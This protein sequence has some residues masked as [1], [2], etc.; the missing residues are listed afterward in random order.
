MRKQ[1][2]VLVAGSSLRLRPLTDATPKCLL[3]VGG[4]TILDRLLER[5]ADAG[6]T[7]GVLVTGYLAHR[8][9]QHLDRSPPPLELTLAPNPDYATTNNAVSLLAARAHLGPGSLI[10]CD[11]DVVLHG[12]A[13]H[14][15]LSEPAPCALLVD[16]QTALGGEEM[17]VLLDEQGR[18]TRLSKALDPAASAGESI[19]IQKVD[20]AALDLL[21]PT[22]GDLVKS[23]KTQVFYE[24]AFQ[25]M[26]DAGTLFRAVPITSDEWTEID[27]LADL[28]DARARFVSR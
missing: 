2:V 20:G 27:S 24:A 22:L 1:A 11:G 12:D 15:L 7:R 8:I 5:L 23:G 17:K 13:L 3:E 28:E 25:Q 9:E 6:V 18:V 21:W 26:I 4:S 19:G 16:G 10:V 14:R